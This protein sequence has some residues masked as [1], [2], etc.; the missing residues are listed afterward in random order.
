[1][2]YFKSGGSNGSNGRAVPFLHENGTLGQ[3]QESGRDQP[4]STMGIGLMG[5]F[6][7]TAWNQGI[8]LY[9]YDDNR[10]A[11][12]AEYVAKY[13][14]GYEVPFETYSWRSGQGGGRQSQTVISDTGRG[15]Y[16]EDSG[17]YDQLGF[18]TLAF[19]RPTAAAKSHKS[20]AGTPPSP[21]A[22][23][24]PSGSPSPSPSG[25]SSESS[26][27]SATSDDGIPPAVPIGFGA[28]SVAALLG[29]IG[30]FRGWFER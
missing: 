18:G 12:G 23:A 30:K 9:G 26:V 13:N 5:A 17:G 19:R 6:C 25:L 14:L 16:G 20:A 3:W 27:V 21:S 10:F 2:T 29:L 15:Q 22:S 7:E 4:H 28:T 24:S 11:K 1:M 8:D